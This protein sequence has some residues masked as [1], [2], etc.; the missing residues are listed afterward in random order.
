MTKP[1]SKTEKNNTT[2]DP[3]IS[4]AP[5]NEKNQNTTDMTMN[6]MAG[7]G[8]YPMMGMGMNPMMGMGMNPMMGGM[9]GMMGFGPAN[10]QY[11]EDPMKELVQ[12]TG[13]IIRQE[14]EFFEVIS[15]CETQNRYQVFLQSPMGLKYAFQCNE[16]SGCCSRCCCPNNCRSLEIIIK[17]LTSAM[18]DPDLA[19]IY[20]K[21]QKPCA[22]GCFCCCRPYIDVVLH[23]DKKYLG[24]V[25]EP[26]TCCDRNAEVYDEFNQLRYRIVGDCCQTGL[27]C[28]S[29]AEKL[30]EIEF[31][32]LEGRK[33]VG[34]MKKMVASL[35]QYFSK[36]DTY[37]I[38]YPKTATPQEKLLLII[39]GLLIDYQ[40][41]EKNSTPEENAKK[42]GL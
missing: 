32:I 9:P 29:S 40:N 7:M 2:T 4:A 12:C 33:N 37:K 42:A 19:N 3:N 10:F 39:A 11:C 35:G 18:E 23:K 15:G 28:G 36:A 5:P 20:I 1:E 14:I 31:N 16:K 22:I 41:F 21:A 26:F 13:A 25:S 34:L 27:C 17:H 30:T 6:P 24:K 38:I 8:M